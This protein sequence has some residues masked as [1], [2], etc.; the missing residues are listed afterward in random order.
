MNDDLLSDAR[1]AMSR[2]DVL[3]AY[4]LAHNVLEV[5]P[6]DLEARFIVSLSL[7][8]SGAADQAGV[9]VA[10]L[11][12]RLATDEGASPRL[13]EDADALVARL[14]K[15]R[16]LACD[17]PER[18]ALARRAA[19]LYEAVAN[20]YNR[21]YSCVNAASLWLIAGDDARAR[22]LASRTLDR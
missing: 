19:Q 10:E 4:D 8:R 17:G 2:G 16:A 20:Q 21:S 7:A 11:R 13:R 15:D 9:E 3:I 6:N 18:T 22:R 5:D 12:R 1:R 14:A